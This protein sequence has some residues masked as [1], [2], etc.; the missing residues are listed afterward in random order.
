MQIDKMSGS[1][2]L[3]RATGAVASEKRLSESETVRLEGEE[4]QARWREAALAAALVLHEKNTPHATVIETA[5]AFQAY[6][7]PSPAEAK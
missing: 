7:Y 2:A 6:L 3:H 5:K 4:G 1:E